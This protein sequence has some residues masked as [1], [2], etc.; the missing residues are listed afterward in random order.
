MTRQRA[1]RRGAQRQAVDA[2][3]IE[4]ATGRLGLPPADLARDLDAADAA[5]RVRAIG[6]L[7]ADAGNA[8]LGSLLGGRGHATGLGVGRGAASTG[9]TDVT[10]SRDI[11][12]I[13]LG[14]PTDEVP[15][16]SGG[17]AAAA[18]ESVGPVAESGY[19]VVA[20]TLA[21]VAAAIGGRPEAGQ[22]SWAP[23]LDFHQTDGIIDS[24]TISVAI[25]LQMP[26]W[27]P[28]STML[29]KAR[30]EWSRW[31]A[32][33]RA[34]EQG[35]IDL[36]HQLFDGQAARMLGKPVA[37][38]QRLFA[39]AKASLAT[40]SR[41]YDARTG[42]GIRQGTVMDVAIEQREIDEEERKRRAAEEQTPRREGAVPVVGDDSAD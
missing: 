41:A 32:A 18:T 25:E 13:D 22:V 42:H 15:Q 10:V 17:D 30:A 33:L 7:Q 27:A 31:Y 34:H 29:P 40:K 26:S 36:V 19:E 23:S 24:V 1:H 38:G 37:T 35:H 4:G 16:L 5:S 28:P 21:D 6:G 39:G 8:A 9:I 3:R 11:E 2:E 12:D 20:S 14:T